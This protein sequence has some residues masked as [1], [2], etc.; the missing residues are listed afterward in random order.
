MAEADTDLLLNQYNI[1]VPD[2]RADDLNHLCRL[3][4]NRQIHSELIS[5]SCA[6]NGNFSRG[7]RPRVQWEYLTLAH[8][9]RAPV[10]VE[11]L[12][13]EHVALSA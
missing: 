3:F 12:S 9:R 4:S 10:R 11:G 6:S 8:L 1:T 13:A 5:N 7:I 2:S